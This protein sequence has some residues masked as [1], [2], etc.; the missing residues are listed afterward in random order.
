MEQKQHDY[1][2]LNRELER[3]KGKLFIQKNAGFLGSLLCSHEIIWDTN[4]DTAW[5]N[6][7][8]IGISPDFFLNLDAETRISLLVHELWH[9]GYDH[10]GRVGNKNPEIWNHAADYVINNQMLKDAF[11]FNGVSPLVNPDFDGMHTE[12]IYDILSK[13]WEDSPQLSLTFGKD[14]V[15]GDPQDSLDVKQSIVKAQQ[16]AEMSN[17]YGDL[18]G[19]VTR[20]LENFLNPVLPWQQ[21]LYRYFNDMCNDDYTWRRPSRRYEEEY[22]PS[23]IS[24]NKLEHLM[25]YVDV[26][27]SVTDEELERF[28]SEV[29]YIH[30]QFKPLKLTVSTFDTVIQDTYIL[31][32]DDTFSRCEITGR[33]GT[34]L[35]PVKKSIKESQPTA[36]VIFSD[37]H[38]YPME[39]N[40]GSPIIWVIMDNPKAVT[41]F[42]TRV[43]MA[44]DKYLGIQDQ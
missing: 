30:S 21:L 2:Y 8:V 22:L 29:A 32:A 24:D 36:A 4:C 44:R 9:T 18:P 6:G 7:K 40:P 14:V 31:A 41:H 19:E 28:F 12:E 34:S 27:G 35:D 37:L 3:T 10:A 23:L 11:T 33:G 26:S 25:Y 17:Q 43:H 39:E 38:C 42:G 1:A 16:A 5:C 13:D 20:V 15:S